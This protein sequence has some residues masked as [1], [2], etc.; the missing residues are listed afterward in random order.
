MALDSV[1]CGESMA[2]HR[3][4]GNSEES[5]KGKMVRGHARTDIACLVV[6]TSVEL[7]FSVSTCGNPRIV[8]QVT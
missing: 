2:M 8:D 5:T 1:T 3:E 4:G 6:Q 7:A